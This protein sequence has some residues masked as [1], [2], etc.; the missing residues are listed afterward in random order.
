MKNKKNLILIFIIIAIICIVF[1][2][3]KFQSSS[4]QE[5]VVNSVLPS[6]QET[7]ITENDD[8]I[9]IHIYGEVNNPGLIE[10]DSGSRVA[11]AIEAA[12]GTTE[13]VDISKVNLAYILSDGEKI[14]IPSINDDDT[15][16]ENITQTSSKININT[17]T[18]T[19]LAMLNGIGNSI[20]EAIIEYRTENGRFKNIED[21]KNVSGIGDSKF[22]KI[23][24]YICTK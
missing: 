13:N 4:Y 8:K 23:K 18:V 1:L 2:K 6:S 19:E 5:I 12:G 3:E 15:I 7:I 10:L 22:E 20:A 24:D 16:I 11:D 9:K 21:I 17:A 14:Y